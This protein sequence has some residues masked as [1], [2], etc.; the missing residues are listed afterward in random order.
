MPIVNKSDIVE[1]DVHP[2]IHRM[3]N[4]N[5]NGIVHDEIGNVFLVNNEWFIHFIEQLETIVD[6]T[7]AR[8]LAHSSLSYWSKIDFSV[9][10]SEINVNFLPQFFVLFILF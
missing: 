6:S 3:N 10:H 1:Y 8:R 9:R 5:S 7:L 4:S 2:I